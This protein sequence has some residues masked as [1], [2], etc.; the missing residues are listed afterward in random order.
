M[1]RKLVLFLLCRFSLQAI[2][3]RFKKSSGINKNKKPIDIPPFFYSYDHI[4]IFYYTNQS[5]FSGIFRDR[6]N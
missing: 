1:I 6:D 5:F 2:G 4:I 3:F